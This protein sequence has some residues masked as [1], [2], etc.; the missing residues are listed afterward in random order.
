M[1]SLIQQSYG[2]GAAAT[3]ERLSEA[4]AVRLLRDEAPA[5]VHLDAEHDDTHS[6]MTRHLDYL[7]PHAIT[8]LLADETRPRATVLGAGALV[9]LR[10]VN[11]NEGQDQEDM[12]SIRIWID[13]HRVIS[14][15]RRK[16]A[17]VGD[18]SDRLKDGRQK[19]NV[20]AFLSTLVER[21][22]DRIERFMGQLGEVCDALEGEVVET[23]DRNLRTKIIETRIAVIVF[24]RHIAPQRD[25]ISD[26]LASDLPWLDKLTR[27]R[28]QEAQDRLMRTVE[29]LDAVRERLQ[30]VKEE[31]SNAL[32]DR[33]NANLYFLAII[34]A[35]FL[36]LGFLTGLFGMNLAGMPGAADPRAFWVTVAGM[37]GVVG[38][39]ITLLKRFRW[40]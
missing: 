3:G 34:S 7:D 36:P 1:S 35:I 39:L 12:V 13:A 25:A 33:L 17:A 30:V 27:R 16:L 15:S 21:L 31:L 20:G 26:L 8:A 6:W 32:A 29:E 11:T 38:L 9:I 4:D 18:L 2:L 40:F 23:P 28:L 10:G 24:R 37:L 19:G 5:W 14:L 22:N